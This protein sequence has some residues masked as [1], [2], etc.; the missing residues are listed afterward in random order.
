[1][2]EAPIDLV[3]LT[4]PEPGFPRDIVPAIRSLVDTRMIRVIDVLFVHKDKLGNVE[5]RELTDLS[6][7]D[8]EVWAP[9][10]HTIK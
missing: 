2:A 8:Q 9:V 7:S 3:V 5:V 6:D 4:S 1:M 10:M